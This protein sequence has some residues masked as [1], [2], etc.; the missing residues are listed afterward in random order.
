[1]DKDFKKKSF[2]N[3]YKNFD[4][5]E[6]FDSSIFSTVLREKSKIYESN[7][8]LIIENYLNFE[9]N[10]ITREYQNKNLYKEKI[11][12]NDK[13]ENIRINKP[14]LAEKLVMGDLEFY[15]KYGKFPSSFFI[16]ILLVIFTTYSVKYLILIIIIFNIKK[17]I[18]YFSFNGIFQMSY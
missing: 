3:N 7:K 14:N 12:L 8:K 15:Y 10:N 18:L 13:K 4:E 6:N 11:N 17:D 16:H 9:D 2:L 1:M 5:S